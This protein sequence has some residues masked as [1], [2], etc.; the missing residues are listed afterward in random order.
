MCS[1]PHFDY[2]SWSMLP[3]FGCSFTEPPGLGPL[4]FFEHMTLPEA[5]CTTRLDKDAM[6]TIRR[7]KRSRVDK[8]DGVCLDLFRMQDGEVDLSEVAHHLMAPTCGY[9]NELVDIIVLSLAE[10][11]RCHF[12][13]DF[14]A[15][16]KAMLGDVYYSVWRSRFY[17]SVY[18]ALR[19]NRIPCFKPKNKIKRRL[20]DKTRRGEIGPV[21]LQTLS[22]L[23]GPER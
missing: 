9:R 8:L 7:L 19:A 22:W 10:T 16:L 2:Y 3:F 18:H 5:T 12:R 15:E 23:G 4:Q 6:A 21:Y 14:D 17:S 11:G 13:A 1:S 20:K